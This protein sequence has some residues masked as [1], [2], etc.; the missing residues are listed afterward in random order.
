MPDGLQRRR[1][2]NILGGALAAPALL[3]PLAARAQQSQRMRRIGLLMGLSEDDPGNKAILSAFRGALQELGW[4]EGRNIQLDF[5]WPAGV[6]QIQNSAQALIASKPDIA[7][8]QSTPTTAALLQQTRT[9]PI[10]FTNVSDP[11][12]SGF[13]SSLPHPGGN[14]TGF[15]DI[16]GAMAGKWLELLKE[17]APRTTRAVAPFNPETAPNHGLYFLE[18]F[19][20]AAAPLGIEAI[21]APVRDAGELETVIAALAREPNCGLVVTPD[22]FLRAQRAA[23]VSL[24]TRYRLPAVYPFRYYCELGGLLS[25]GNDVVDN[26][27]RTAS[28]VDRILKGEKPGELPVQ[29]PVKFEMVINLKTAK[30]LGLDVPAT[31]LARADEVIE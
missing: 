23:I 22:G 18:P 4:T 12:G 3:R 25:Y 19:K 26:W 5:R 24:A 28:Y 9:I 8:T 15:I 31:L 29:I 13:V 20:A 16:E 21:A 6:E 1:F 11:V 7:I 14:L 10:V 17:I 27:R 2:I 30:A